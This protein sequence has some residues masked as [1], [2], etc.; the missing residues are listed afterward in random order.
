MSD[1]EAAYTTLHNE[2]AQRNKS[3]CEELDHVVWWIIITFGHRI[4]IINS[5][6]LASAIHLL[7]FTLGVV[8]VVHLLLLL[9]TINATVLCMRTLLDLLLVGTLLRHSMLNLLIEALL[10]EA[11]LLFS[12]LMQ[13]L[14]ET[15]GRTFGMHAGGLWAAGR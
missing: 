15:L 14:V 8:G 9:T 12:A 7:A 3:G 1:K 11:T 6:C 5:R 10:G 2:V 13:L 4:T